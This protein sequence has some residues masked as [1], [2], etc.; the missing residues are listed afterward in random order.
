MNVF[1]VVNLVVLILVVLGLLLLA[2]GFV[3]QRYGDR[4]R[5]PKRLLTRITRHLHGHI[6]TRLGQPL[7]A[8]LAT[9]DAAVLEQ[10]RCLTPDQ[11][12]AVA[13]WLV[14]P[15]THM[16]PAQRDRMIAAL[17]QAEQE[18]TATS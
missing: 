14:D 8:A 3:A 15:A 7:V 9:S 4:R 17:R 12:A 10:A 2:F 18:T 6:D 5:N 16:K 1:A 13:L 11:R